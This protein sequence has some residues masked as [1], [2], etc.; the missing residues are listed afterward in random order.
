MKQIGQD[1]GCGRALWENNNDEDTLRH[2]DGAHAAAVL[3]RRLHRLDG[4]P[5]LRGLGHHAVPLPHRQRAVR[6]QLEP[7]APPP[8]R[9]RRRRQGRAVPADARRAVLPRLQPGG[10]RQGRHQPDAHPGRPVRS[11]EGLRGRRTPTWSCRSRP[12]RSW[13][14]AP[15]RTATRWLELG[16]SYFQNEDAWPAV[17]GGRSGPSDWQRDRRSTRHR[18]RPTT[19]PS[20]RWRRRRPIQPAP[21]PAG[22]GQ[23]REA[24]ATTRISFKVDQVGV[25]V[26]V[27]A[28]YF[29]NWEVSGAKGPYRVAPNFMVVIPTSNEVT[30][31]YGYTAVEYLVVLPVVRRHRRA[32]VPV[33]QGPDRLRHPARRRAGLPHRRPASTSAWTPPPPAEPITFLVDWDEDDRGACGRRT[34]DRRA[35]TPRRAAGAARSDRGSRSVAAAARVAFG[36]SL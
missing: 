10:D 33:A 34:G 35:P 23:R 20:P 18:R 19:A 3:D 32:G 28:S 13:R 36:P 5:V 25:P 14:P 30:L 2:A 4:G 27:K 15:T 29:P 11:V 6:A 26:L 22:H 17:P 7:G 21:L 1:S 24:R 16:T 8:V 31:H 12:S 9:R